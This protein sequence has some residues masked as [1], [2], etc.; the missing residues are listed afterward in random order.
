VSA[1]SRARRVAVVGAG[2]SGVAAAH[3]LKRRGFEPELLEASSALGGR[4]G[5]ALLGDKSVDIGGKNIGRRYV[6]FREFWREHGAPPLEYFGINSSTVR[7]GRLHTLDSTRKLASLAHV[8]G[9]TGARD[10]AR[11]FGLGWL[12]RRHPEEG[13]LGGRRFSALAEKKDHLPLSAWFGAET[14]RSFLRP[15]TLR[16]NGA[17]PDEYALGCFGSN[18]RMVL[19]SY[20]Q[21]TLG[22]SDLLR[23]FAGTVRVSLRTRVVG[24]QWVGRR[25]VGLEVEGPEGRELRPYDWVVLALPGP[26]SAALLEGDAVHALLGR[27]AYNPVTLVV[28]RYGRPIFDERVRAIVFGPDSPVSNAGCYGVRDRDVVRYTLSGRAARGIDASSD[29]EKVVR[30]AEDQLRRFVPVAPNERVDYVFRHFR[31][32]LCAY[33]P[34]HHR[35][36]E[37]LL[38]WE[39]AVR[40]V[41]LTGDYVRGASIEAC[42]ESAFE[43]VER[44]TLRMAESPSA[45]VSQGARLRR[46]SAVHPAG[47]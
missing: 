9:L 46:D 26:A 17:E 45:G 3:F 12:V 20:D 37:A 42:F 16:M 33:T 2:V 35:L 22:M 36:I 28:A 27:I 34:H 14:V 31:H 13:M 43:C 47:A 7:N 11:L 21:L 6:R 44:L 8:L 25:V 30:S 32:G 15:I 29:P 23:R 4:A 39:S 10:F 40:G 19:D 1:P 41:S 38:G 18:L 5:G 24:L